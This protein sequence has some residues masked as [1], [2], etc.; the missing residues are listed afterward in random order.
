MVARDAL[1]GLLSALQDA[2]LDDT[3]WPAASA[4][5]D[6]AVGSIGNGLVI[7]EGPVDDIRIIFAAAYCRGWRDFDRE[8]TYLRDYYAS[9]ERVPRIRKLSNGKLVHVTDLYSH[10][11]LKTS[12][13]YNEFLLRF[14]GQNSLNARLDAGGGTHVTWAVCDPVRQGRWHPDKLAL[15][16]RL[17]SPIRQLVRVRQAMASARA[18]GSSFAAL[19]G[20]SR[21]GIVHLDRRRRIIEANDRAL[22]ILRHGYGLSDL[23][24]Y[25][26][27]WLPADDARLQGLLAAAIPHYGGGQGVAGSMGIERASKLPKL[28]LHVTPVDGGRLHFGSPGVAALVLI[29]EPDRPPRLDVGLVGEALGLSP[30]E[31]QVAVMLSE[32]RAVR[33]IAAATGRLPGTVHDLTKNAYKKLGIS[34]QVDLVRLVLQL[35]DFSASRD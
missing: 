4:L 15:I 3:L 29:V 10:N 18:L 33:E 5:I 11:E 35:S 9:D 25:L 21:I 8:R 31:S 14:N 19:L 1:A 17:L 26:G 28:V 24:G 34:R 22:G 20:N 27:A 2:A 32:G 23:G 30:A 16:E 13:T 12:P 7:G 6:E